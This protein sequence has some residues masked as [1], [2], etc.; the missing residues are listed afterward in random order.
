M[1]RLDGTM[2][3][4]LQTGQSQLE[5]VRRESNYTPTTDIGHR[6]SLPQCW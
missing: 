3:L 5:D 2:R 6:V 4:P 1:F